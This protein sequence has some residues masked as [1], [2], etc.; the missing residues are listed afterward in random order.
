MSTQNPHW[1][2]GKTKG[3]RLR[4]LFNESPLKANVSKILLYPSEE[5]GD[6]DGRPLREAVIREF[7]SSSRLAVRSSFNGE[8]SQSSHAGKF[9]SILNVLP[10]DVPESIAA[11]LA[12]GEESVSREY[13]GGDK[14]HVIVQEMVGAV[15]RAGVLFTA[16]PSH[17]SFAATLQWSEGSETD[18][19]TAGKDKVRTIQIP[20]GIHAKETV[21]HPLLRPFNGLLELAVKLQDLTGELALDIEFAQD[22]HGHWWILQVRP[23]WSGN[24]GGSEKFVSREAESQQSSMYLAQLNSLPRGSVHNQDSGDAILG[25]M[26]DWNPAELIGTAPNQLAM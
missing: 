11:V 26:P 10:E 15:A 18:I 23:I 8:D 17:R 6:G 16:N 22:S 1:F 21:S 5:L 20:G 14:P 7:G 25:V 13:W 9:L 3:E 4:W 2:N 19:V 24:A 12:S